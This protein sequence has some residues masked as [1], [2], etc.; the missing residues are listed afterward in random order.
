MARIAS[1]ILSNSGPLQLYLRASFLNHSCCNNC[2][3]IVIGQHV[4]IYATKD[5]QV[6]SELLISYVDSVQSLA[7]RN[8]EGIKKLSCKCILCSCDDSRTFKDDVDFKEYL[9]S[10]GNKNPTALYSRAMK[11]LLGLITYPEVDDRTEI[12]RF[13]GA[14]AKVY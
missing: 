5:I 9:A 3:R 13:I 4:L 2:V 8:K 7:T 10:P 12:D 6:D 1:S 11:H 14:Y